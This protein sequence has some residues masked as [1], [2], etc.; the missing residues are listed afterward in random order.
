MGCWSCN[1]LMGGS[2]YAMLS[3]GRKKRKW[4]CAVIR[5]EKNGSIS[6][7]GLHEEKVECVEE[8]A[9]CLDR[10]SNFRT[11]S[12]TLMNANSSRSHAIF[13]ISIE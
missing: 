12:A 8:M 13:T 7:Y 10:G 3:N 2:G 5:E 4:L 9:A 6:V 1:E 11:T